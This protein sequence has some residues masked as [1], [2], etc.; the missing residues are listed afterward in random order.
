MEKFTIDN[1]Q[2]QY[3]FSLYN[4]TEGEKL[5][6]RQDVARGYFNQLTEKGLRD[7]PIK[8]KVLR[9]V[10]NASL[11]LLASTLE[12]VLA[13]LSVGGI[14]VRFDDIR[15]KKEMTLGSYRRLQRRL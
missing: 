15:D 7:L 9:V 5:E 6:Y 12:G 10:R 2:F 8:E 1:H 11:E 14:T 3:P 13:P 4:A